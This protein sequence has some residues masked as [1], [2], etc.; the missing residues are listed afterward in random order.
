[1]DKK[2]LLC[3]WVCSGASV[4]LILGSFCFTKVIAQYV[5]QIANSDMLSD[6]GGLK[7]SQVFYQT[8]GINVSRKPYTYLLNGNVNVKLLGFIE[9]P[10]LFFYS[11]LGS[12]FTQPTFNQTSL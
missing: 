9:A 11:N 1:M 12:G 5:Q 10:F 7:I 6:S 4:S 8:Y 2:L 3:K